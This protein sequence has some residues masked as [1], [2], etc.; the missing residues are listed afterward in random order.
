MGKIYK[1]LNEQQEKFCDYFIQS[2]NPE[3][4]ALK[5]GY[6][7]LGARNTAW[8]LLK[9]PHIKKRINQLK[10][11]NID[12]SEFMSMHDIVN[13]HIKIIKANLSDF[14]EFGQTTNVNGKKTTYFYLKNS[15][16]LDLTALES[17]QQGKDGIKI[18][19]ID[20]KFSIEYITKLLDKHK[21]DSDINFESIEDVKKYLSGLLLKSCELS[22]LTNKNILN[23]TSKIIECFKTD[24]D[25]KLNELEEIINKILEKENGDDN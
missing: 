17:I 14:I 3:I 7:K 8:R 10:D 21:L 9:E 13:Y 12:L 6:K 19:L 2:Y 4:S 11:D 22:E 1:K 15:K 23:I 16:N 5:A 18:K 24:Q 20:K 25:E